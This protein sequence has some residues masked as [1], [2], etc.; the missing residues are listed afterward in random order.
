MVFTRE[1][2][3]LVKEGE[4]WMKTTAESCSITA[5]LITTIVFAAAITVP[6]GSNQE[7]GIPLHK[8]RFAFTIFAAADAISLFASATALLVFLS[9][10][11]ARFSEQ[12]FLVS[13]PRRMII[14]LCTLFLSATMMMVAFSATLYLVFVEQ[15]AWMLAPIGGLTCLPIAAFITLQFPLVVDLFRSTYFPIFGKRSYIEHGKFNPNDIQS[16]F[17]NREIE[18]ALQ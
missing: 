15:R 9:I 11:T 16:Y 6:G 7:T 13:L 17:G 2:K 18:Y 5:A 1:H 8:K 12:D 10:L 4:K 14:G 3:D